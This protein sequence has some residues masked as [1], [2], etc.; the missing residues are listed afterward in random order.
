MKKIFYLY[1]LFPMIIGCSKDTSQGMCFESIEYI[2]D[3]PCYSQ[4]QHGDNYSID[5][6]GKVDLCIQDSFLIIN[7]LD[8]NGKWNF[9]STH[10]GE[11]CGR[12]F[13]KGHG[14]CEFV[15]GPNLDS[16]TTF[17]KK[18][19]NLYAT[20]YDFGT[21]KLYS[22]D[23][24]ESLKSQE[25]LATHYSYRFDRFLG[26]C[27]LLDSGFSDDAC[28]LIQKMNNFTGNFPLKICSRG[29]ELTENDVVSQ[30]NAFHLEKGHRQTVLSSFMRYNLK[31]RRIVQ[32]P[33]F[34]NYINIFNIDGT[35]C[36]TICIDPQLIEINENVETELRDV[37]DDVRVFDDF[38]VVMCDME[39]R[40]SLLFFDYEGRPLYD[41]RYNNSAN[42]FDIDMKKQKLY[43]L[44]Y[45]ND[46]IEYYDVSDVVETINKY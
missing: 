16:N 27:I 41:L 46:I 35:F 43:L 25:I 24:Q 22:V 19:G 14:P 28:F 38:F 13:R 7:T 40:K 18:N 8:D 12:L 4:L 10:S 5:L 36:K 15:Q 33:L 6:I 23:I 26:N 1:V 45:E 32:V 37:F 21:G 17:Y 34:L 31:N 42:R 29:K 20:V 30:L 44:D 3:F 9:F 39:K 11:F 2:Q